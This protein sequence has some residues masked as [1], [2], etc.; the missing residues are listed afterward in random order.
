MVNKVFN[1]Y[2][3]NVFLNLFFLVRILK[4]FQ[5]FKLFLILR[6][7]NLDILDLSWRL[8]SWLKRRNKIDNIHCS[9]TD[10]G[11]IFKNLIIDNII[12]TVTIWFA[13]SFKFLHLFFQIYKFLFLILFLILCYNI[14][15]IHKFIKIFYVN[16]RHV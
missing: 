2:F 5:V 6:I 10:S 12:Y 9:W 1:Y 8:C 14:V 7:L 16:G 15:L 4:L 13:P 11:I 3:F